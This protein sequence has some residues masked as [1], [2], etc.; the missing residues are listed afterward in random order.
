MD[1]VSVGLMCGFVLVSACV[2]SKAVRSSGQIGCSPDE[3]SISE[4]RNH[5]GLVQSGESWVAECRGRTFICSQMNAVQGQNGSLGTALMASEQVSC[6]EELESP[7][8]ERNRL[9]RQAALAAQSRRPSPAPTGAA[10]FQFGESKED[11]QRRCETAA[12][13]WDGTAERPACSGNSAALGLSARIALELCDGRVCAIAIEHKPRGNWSTSI[14]GLKATLE[15]K[16]G[17]PSSGESS[18]IIPKE[19]RTEAE[20]TQCLESSALSLQFEWRWPSGESLKLAVGKLEPATPAS[21]RLVYRRPDS[22]VS[23]SAL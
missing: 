1:K 12:M 10:G 18:G 7:E 3:V 5:F 17:R 21:V 9:A 16:Y 15:A 11:A 2:P 6:R 19:C 22:A 23:S 20:F 14:A 13:I 4:D 8:E